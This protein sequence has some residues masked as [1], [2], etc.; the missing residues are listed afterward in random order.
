PVRSLAPCIKFPGC[1]V[2]FGAVPLCCQIPRKPRVKAPPVKAVRHYGAYCAG[3][4]QGRVHGGPGAAA[5]SQQTG[6]LIARRPDQGQG[7]PSL[8]LPQ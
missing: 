7:L 1:L 8:F 4:Q 6:P 2:S 5:G 3:C